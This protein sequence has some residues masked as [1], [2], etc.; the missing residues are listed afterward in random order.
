MSATLER[1]LRGKWTRMNLAAKRGL[2]RVC[3]EW[4]GED[5]FMEFRRWALANEW[6]PQ[7]MSRRV[8]ARRDPK[9]PW[10]ED[11]CYVG[12]RPVTSGKGMV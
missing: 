5:G 12:I 11:N 10:S 7:R 1:R 3:D 6:D 2:V 9:G 8:I 4:R